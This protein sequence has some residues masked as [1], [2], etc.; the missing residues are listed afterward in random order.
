VV[1]TLSLLAAVAVLGAGAAGALWWRMQRLAAAHAA[2]EEEPPL[3]GD[4]DTGEPL[5]ARLRW[6]WRGLRGQPPAAAINE[7]RFETLRGV[8]AAGFADGSSR[9][10]PAP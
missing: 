8:P 7:P 3:F 4:G 10:E 5:V 9:K 2:G 1:T 6:L